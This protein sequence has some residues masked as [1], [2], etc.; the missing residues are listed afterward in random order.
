MDTIR[1]C[2]E[3]QKPLPQNAPEGLCPECLARVA[4][5]SKPAIPGKRNPPDSAELAA[6]FPQLEVMELLGM[7]GIDRKSVV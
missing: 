1:I 5:G 7:G 3:C 6:Q 2:K 4:L